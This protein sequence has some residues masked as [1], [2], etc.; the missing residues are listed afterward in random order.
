VLST[1]SFAETGTCSCPGV[2]GVTLGG[3]VGPWSG[4]HGMLIDALLSLRVVTATGRVV[5]VSDTSNPDLFW[6][7]RGAGANYGIVISATYKLQKQVNKGQL[8]VADMVFTP[9][10]NSSYFDLVATYDGTLPKIMSISSFL[11]YDAVNGVS[12]S[13]HAALTLKSYSI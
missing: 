10:K 3:G 11:I 2:V 4:V 8:V 13:Q 12:S 6:A 7:F 5:E 9:D 1:D